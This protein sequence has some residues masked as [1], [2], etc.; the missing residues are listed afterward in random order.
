MNPEDI[1]NITYRGGPIDDP[2]IL[3][4][5]PPEIQE[6]LQIENGFILWNGGLHFRGACKEPKW[7][8]LRAAIEGK[9]SLISLYST[10]K[11]G[12]IPFAQDCM[13]DQFI[14]RKNAVLFLAAET[15]EL[16]QFSSDL[17]EF[18]SKAAQ[19][20]EEYL[21]I[22]LEYHLEPGDLFHAHPPFCFES[23]GDV[24]L[25]AI[26]AQQVI[27]FHAHFASEISNLPNG[28]YVR[29]SFP[30]KTDC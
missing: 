11:V 20:P 29:F 16:E 1:G 4:H 27:A 19:D 10:L 14:L 28:T 25:R 22:N 17:D 23:E 9:K 26:P 12:D 13:G 30:E 15:G 21:N 6:M 3:P 24:S 7:H 8:S 5:L 18:F 2:E